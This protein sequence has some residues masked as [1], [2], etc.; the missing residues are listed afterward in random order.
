MRF[1]DAHGTPVMSRNDA[2]QL[3]KVR[4]L[5]VDV[6]HRRV[7]AVHIDG[8]RKRALL[9]EWRALSGF[10]PD[11][12]VV[13]DGG[14]LRGP[15]DERE[16]AMVAGDLDWLGRRVLTDRGESAGAVDDVEF[17]EDSGAL[18]SIVTTRATYGADRLVALGPYCVIVRG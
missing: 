12:V 8:R 9:V 7:T 5:L 2:E 15:A 17:D 14:A 1:S 10:G 13:G 11:A 16:L 6:G 18:T 3:G 4:R